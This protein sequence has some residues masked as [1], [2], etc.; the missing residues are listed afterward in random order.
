MHP[1]SYTP[2][3]RMNKWKSKKIGSRPMVQI[4]A[5][6]TPLFRMQAKA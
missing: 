4:G 5:P 6:Q 3:R 2:R 1:S